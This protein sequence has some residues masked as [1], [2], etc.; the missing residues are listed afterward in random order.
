MTSRPPE[1]TG[2]GPAP[3]PPSEE[4]AQVVHHLHGS[5]VLFGVLHGLRGSSGLIVIAFFWLFFR[6]S[7]HGPLHS[8]LL[9][10]LFL[11]G[12]LLLSLTANLI[13]YLVLRIR[14]E[15]DE[16]II[17][18]GFIFRSERHIPY[19]R[20][21]NIDVIQSVLHRPFNVGVV[22][23]ETSSGGEVEAE[24]RVLSLAAVETMRTRVFGDAAA[25]ED[26]RALAANDPGA[27]PAARSGTVEAAAAR[28]LLS[29]RLS[30]LILIGLITNR[31]LTFVAVIFGA[32]WQLEAQFEFFDRYD[33]TAW[34]GR[35][36]DVLAATPIFFWIALAAGFLAV[37][38]A[39]S[40]CWS[41]VRFYGFRL[42][43]QGDDLRIECGLF[44]RVRAT[45]PRR[46]IQFITV[47]QTPLHRL[48]GRATMRVE[49]A[50]TNIQDDETSLLSRRWFVPLLPSDRVDEMIEAVQPAFT[51][52]D[53]DWQPLAPKARRRLLR[54]AALF[55]AA[56]G[57]AAVLILPWEV[58]AILWAG[59]LL[60]ALARAWRLPAVTRWSV[61]DRRIVYRTGVFT[62]LTSITLFSRVQTVATRQTPFDRRW[63]M[64]ALS[65]DTAG[66]G[67]A[68]HLIDIHELPEERADHLRREIAHGAERAGFH[69]V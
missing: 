7:D 13:R 52:R 45:I 4:A 41:V 15:G 37:L 32:A 51:I 50:G 46:R 42:Q 36:L 40:I 30:E 17:K 26:G 57:L 31:G 49:T 12:L 16:L 1:A 33:L 8:F 27:G 63:S 43:R 61:T 2:A 21:Q 39:F 69:W 60:V 25:D 55:T 66:A 29:L 3:E 5:S 64:A 65:V 34:A 14:Y 58:G 24:L 54:R 19:R 53:A 10:A 20:I 67:T 48:F 38:Y 9:F 22:K 28:D 35:L 68:G 56:P 62:R 47:R 59:V 44:T 23:I 11:T 6:E 18:R